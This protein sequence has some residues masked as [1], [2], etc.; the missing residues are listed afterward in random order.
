MTVV[1]QHV[2]VMRRKL[3]D[4]ALSTRVC[5]DVN[6]YEAGKAPTGPGIHGIVVVGPGYVVDGSLRAVNVW[7][8]FTMH[9]LFTLP[10][11]ER[12]EAEAEQVD[13]RLTDARDTV[14]ASLLANIVFGDGVEL[15]PMGHRG[16]RIRWSSGYLD[17]DGQMF[18]TATLV[19][20]FVAFN[21]IEV[22][23]T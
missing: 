10:L 6:G 9:F 12:P 13:P 23:R 4:R 11:A 16:E 15:D 14:L 21:A 8:A 2:R 5:A 18:R 3:I 20:G 7:Q 22:G 1:P 17:W 19:P